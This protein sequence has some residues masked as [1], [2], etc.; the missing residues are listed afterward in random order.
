MTPA[1]G[2][3]AGRWDRYFRQY[4]DEQFPTELER[5]RWN[6]K[7][8]FCML[9]ADRL[10]AATG[11]ARYLRAILAARP[12]LLDENGRIRNFSAEEYNLDKISFG[13]SLLV[14]YRHTQ[15]SGCLAA[16]MQCFR[17][18]QSY[19]R[20]RS[21]GFFHKDI[22]P[23]QIWL[24]G[25][26]MAL[27]FYV[28]CEILCGTMRFDDILRQFAGVRGRLYVERKGLYLHAWDESRRAEWADPYTGLSP[29][30]WLRAE[31]W[32]LMALCDCY[33]LLR[34]RTPE[35]T[36]LA[37]LLDE[38]LS[39]LLP[40]RDAESGMF[41]QVIDRADVPENYPETSGSAMIA[42][43]MMKSARLRMTGERC[44]RTGRELLDAVAKHSL[45][46]TD[47][48]GLRLHGICASAGLGPGP[49]RRT[50]RDGTVRYYLSEPRIPD[51]PHGA[52][53]CMLAYGEAL[54]LPDAD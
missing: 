46:E 40:Y 42:Y 8:D 30:H 15:D 3:Q 36:L 18:L 52:A 25:L 2:A 53:A 39:G 41:L 43:A 10:Y 47:G 17:Q 35:A 48:G 7:H 37:R 20:T 33:E 27:P 32:L 13:K 12:Y 1:D 14:L 16:A 24:D 28:S 34:D 19:P 4:I 44:A 6:Y 50:D 22:Y 9:G 45:K 11:Q 21:G 31:G 49:D 38:A 54:Q 23:F 29:T 51:N 26:Y 5:H